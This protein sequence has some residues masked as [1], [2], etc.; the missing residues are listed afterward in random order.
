MYKNYVQ[1]L[2]RPSSSQPPRLITC[3]GQGSR[4]LQGHTDP[5]RSR[6]GQGQMWSHYLYVVLNFPRIIVYDFWSWRFHPFIITNCNSSRERRHVCCVTSSVLGPG[7]RCH[8]WYDVIYTTTILLHYSS[9]RREAQDQNQHVTD[10]SYYVTHVIS[11]FIGLYWPVTMVTQVCYGVAMTTR[12]L[13]C[14]CSIFSLFWHYVKRMCSLRVLYTSKQTHSDHIIAF[15]I[16]HE[17]WMMI[18]RWWK[19]EWF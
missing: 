18:L 14:T 19:F 11:L 5:P 4:T 1:I 7:P 10:S 16:L 3:Q 2:P 8:L 13:S 12:A 17:S 15:F 9:V 6:T